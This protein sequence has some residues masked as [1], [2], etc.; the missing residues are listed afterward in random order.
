MPMRVSCGSRFFPS[1]VF[2]RL[3]AYYLHQEKRFRLL[4]DWVRQGMNGLSDEGRQNLGP[5]CLDPNCV[6]ARERRVVGHVWN[7]LFSFAVWPFYSLLLGAV[8]LG[9]FALRE[10]PLS[11]PPEAA[12][13]ATSG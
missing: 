3:D 10:R 4:F 1:W 5:F 2:A 12:H 9:V 13:R 6:P 8:L 11:N 7:R